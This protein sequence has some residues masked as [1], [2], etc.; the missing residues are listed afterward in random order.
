MLTK[1]AKAIL[2]PVN[3]RLEHGFPND[4]DQQKAERA[5]L[6]HID[7][8]DSEIESEGEEDFGEEGTTARGSV[9]DGDGV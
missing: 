2:R 1:P 8:K 4:G 6:Y 3:D 7:A 9:V 5:E